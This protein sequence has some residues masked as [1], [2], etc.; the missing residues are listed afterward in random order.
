[1]SNKC[2]CRKLIDSHEIEASQPRVQGII[3]QAFMKDFVLSFIFRGF[4]IGNDKKI[5]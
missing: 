5:D 3:L 4:L 1:M 2:Y